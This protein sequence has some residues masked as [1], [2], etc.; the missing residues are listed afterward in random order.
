MTEAQRNILNDY[1]MA[2]AGL[3]S[4]GITVFFGTVTNLLY[5][6]TVKGERLIHPDGTI[7]YPDGRKVRP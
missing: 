4:T 3:G 2:Y 5:I 1:V 7:E 6:G